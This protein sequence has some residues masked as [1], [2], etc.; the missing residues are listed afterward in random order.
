MDLRDAVQ[1][2]NIAA[3][4]VVSHRGTTPIKIKELVEH[5]GI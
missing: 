5:I 1:V 4:I 3:G 2:A